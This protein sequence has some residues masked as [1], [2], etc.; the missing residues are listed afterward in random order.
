MLN[1]LLFHHFPSLKSV[2]TQMLY[3]Y[4]STRFNDK[5][6]VFMNFGYVP[7]SPNE[8]KLPLLPEEEGHRFSAQLYHHIAKTIPWE[9]A[10]VLEVSSGRGGGA[11][12]IMRHF[13]PR[14]Y[15]GVDYSARAVEFCQRHYHVSGLS[16][17][18]GNAEAL[19]FPD[20][21]FDIVINLEAS[22]YYP[23]IPRFF[24]HVRRLLKP[25]GY[26]LYADLRYEEKIGEWRTQLL[27]T[28]LKLIK[29]EEITNNVLK[30]I[31]LDRERRIR[32]V[33]RYTPAIMHTIS[34][35]L[36][37]LEPGAPEDVTPHLD[38]R[39]Y[40]HFILQKV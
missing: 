25:N 1:K 21:S 20:S 11:N 16:F 22:M 35:Q 26:F 36:A 40:W 31:E 38:R 34:Y 17:E 6:A 27:N 30:A 14:S 10:D 2:L 32:L 37:G 12:F 33:K 9:N 19:T 8:S 13:K 4:L 24:E 15:K 29:E 23:N 7:S 3:D 39:K 5:D 18:Y 28:G